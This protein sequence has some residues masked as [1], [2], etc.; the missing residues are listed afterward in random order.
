[1]FICF[2]C[3]NTYLSVK[4]LF[5]HFDLQHSNHNFNSYK[6]AEGECSRLFYL[7]NSYSKHLLRHS[8]DLIQ[9]STP[10][11]FFENYPTLE[12]TNSTNRSSYSELCVEV[13]PLK[14]L[15]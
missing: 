13:E 12:S 15:K 1:M 11:L 2:I 3:K 10:Q 6:C 14:I 9:P 5:S 8:T 4:I 7:K